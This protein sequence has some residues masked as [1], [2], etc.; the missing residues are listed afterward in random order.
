MHE[1]APPA[2]SL[3]SGLEQ[4]SSTK[5]P[6]DVP[7]GIKLFVLCALKALSSP[8]VRASFRAARWVWT[9]EPRLVPPLLLICCVTLA[10]RGLCLGPGKYR[11]GLASQREPP[12]LTPLAPCLAAV[13]PA[14]VCAP[15]AVLGDDG[16][17]PNPPSRLSHPLQLRGVRGAVPSAAAWRE[18]GLQAG[19]ELGAW[20]GRREGPSSGLGKSP[21]V[22][23]GTVCCA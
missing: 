7:R 10:S 5:P 21:S 12:A 9:A 18:A 2:P 20:A 8:H 16:D 11:A 22:L 1:L 14:P 6:R 23:I 3:L 15:A 19:T 17:H 13:R 4:S